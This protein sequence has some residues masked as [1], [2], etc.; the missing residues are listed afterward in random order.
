MAYTQGPRLR[1]ED[2]F[3]FSCDSHD[4]RTDCNAYI[5]L[6]VYIIAVKEIHMKRH[7]LWFAILIFFFGCSDDS[8]NTANDSNDSGSDAASDSA[9]ATIP[10]TGS[11]SDSGSDSNRDSGATG[12]DSGTPTSEGDTLNGSGET[13]S[14]CIDCVPPFVDADSDSV[15]DVQDNCPQLAN[16]NQADADAD[17]VGD[18]CDNCPEFGNFSQSDTDSN[19]IGDACQTFLPSDDDSDSVI[20]GDNCPAVANATQDD[21]DSDGVGDVCDN[22]PFTTNVF[23]EDLDGNGVGDYCE[24]IL[25][26]PLGTPIC[27]AGSTESVR[28]ASNLYILLDLSTSM[29]FDAGDSDSTRWEVVTE[30]LDGV[31]DELAAGFNIGL[32]TFPARCENQSGDYNCQD[33]PSVCS[34]TML[35][36]EILPMQ[37]GR[38]GEVIRDTYNSITPFGTTPTATALEQVLAKRSFELPEDPFAA[39]RTSAVVL[40][41]DGEPNSASDKCNTRADMN[42]TVDAA[43]ALAAAGINVYVIGMT[44]VNEDSMED[45]AVA[46]GGNNPN[47]PERT[48]FP[49]EGVESLSEA[50]LVIAGASI[51]CTLSVAADAQD[52]PDWNRASLV[53]RLAEDNSRILA[54]DEYTL[55]TSDPV[56]MALLGEAFDELQTSAG[57]G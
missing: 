40:I 7:L 48:W 20:Y 31:S 54:S 46:G 19:G 24:E 51:G 5:Q 23:Q 55:N 41:T 39:A 35:P 32:G 4:P 50:L 21:T 36:D 9:T 26:I 42:N 1:G 15:A 17:G 18:V 57:S 38:D 10:D 27:A 13:D 3:F 29:T 25:E 22:C 6:F 33:T 30:A 37:A 16:A 44:G 14:I 52:L 28:L 12:S 11:D 43:A 8:K 56:T 34:A 47:D 2:T 53:M 49:A 45:I